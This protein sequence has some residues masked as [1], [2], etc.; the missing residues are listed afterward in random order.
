MEKVEEKRRTNQASRGSMK[1]LHKERK[2]P[3]H[4]GPLTCLHIFLSM[5][6]LQGPDLDGSFTQITSQD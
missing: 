3:I 2:E 5:Q 1:Y 6:K 4:D